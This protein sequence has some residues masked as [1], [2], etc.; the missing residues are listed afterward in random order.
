MDIISNVEAVQYLTQKNPF[1]SNM[2]G[3]IIMR[4]F[5]VCNASK[6]TYPLTQV[7]SMAAFSLYC[8]AADTTKNNIDLGDGWQFMIPTFCEFEPMEVTPQE[9]EI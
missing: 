3:T 5:M 2:G 7:R 1:G 4:D 6:Q 9:L 8:P